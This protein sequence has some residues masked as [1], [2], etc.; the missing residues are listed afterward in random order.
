MPE[1]L[2]WSICWEKLN[3]KHVLKGYKEKK[4]KSFFHEFKENVF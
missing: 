2:A 4:Q 3:G 1:E